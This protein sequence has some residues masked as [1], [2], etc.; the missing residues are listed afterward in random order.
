MDF[1]QVELDKAAM[2]DTLMTRHFRS[3]ARVRAA[4]RGLSSNSYHG[5]SLQG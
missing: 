5:F 3:T 4:A 1:I 2:P